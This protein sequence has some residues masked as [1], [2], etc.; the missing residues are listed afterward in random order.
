MSSTIHLA[1]E[2]K[3]DGKWTHL[4][5]LSSEY[6]YHTP[7]TRSLFKRYVSGL[8]GLSLYRQMTKKGFWESVR[9]VFANANAA[10]KEEV[11][12][13]PQPKYVNTPLGKMVIRG[14]MDYNSLNFRD[15]FLSSRGWEHSDIAQRGLPDDV[16]DSLRDL[17]DR[18]YNYDHTWFSM[19]ELDK[20]TDLYFE[21]LKGVLRDTEVS[22]RLAAIEAK[23]DG[24]KEEEE[25]SEDEEEPYDYDAE[26]IEYYEDCY[27]CLLCTYTAV[28]S[29]CEEHG[30]DYWSNVRVIGWI[31]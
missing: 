10:Y 9:D 27:N 20:M 7:S 5:W 16:T 8:K 12:D 15:Y 6:P 13:V 30:V 19:E 26:R 28:R 25:K 3:K 29:V 21:K 23:L 4:Q 22:K 24:K 17:A 31:S 1:V 14:E 11:S 2:Y 18:K